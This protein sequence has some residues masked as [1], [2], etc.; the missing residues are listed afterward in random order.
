M[1]HIKD[2]IPFHIRKQLKICFHILRWAISKSKIVDIYI[3]I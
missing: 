2:Y 1:G 3:Y